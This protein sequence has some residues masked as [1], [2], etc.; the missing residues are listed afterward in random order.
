V[1]FSKGKS[2][3]QTQI[4]VLDV[5]E[6]RLGQ[7][8]P[9]FHRHSAPELNAASFSVLYRGKSLDLTAK[10]PNDFQVWTAGLQELIRL[11]RL[12][13]LQPDLPDLV[14]EVKIRK[15][16]RSST[17]LKDARTGDALFD[18]VAEAQGVRERSRSAGGNDKVLHSAVQKHLHKHAARHNVLARKLTGDQK[19]RLSG[20]YPS[21]VE[22]LTMIG[23]GLER[24]Q[25]LMRDGAFEAADEECWRA[26]VGLESLAGFMSAAK[27]NK[28]DS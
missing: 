27:L 11:A 8:T 13:D 9:V 16:R 20:Q 10:D 26:S 6:L 18:P 12:G 1:W 2:I 25:G 19:L 22:K 15:D 23:E 14:L 28:L 5:E 3:K 21:C 24:A 7:T 4:A 17:S